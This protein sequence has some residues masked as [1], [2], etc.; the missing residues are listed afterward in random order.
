VI[1]PGGGV[2]KRPLLGSD[3]KGLLAEI[4]LTQAD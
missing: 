3:H 2:S 4:T 1:A